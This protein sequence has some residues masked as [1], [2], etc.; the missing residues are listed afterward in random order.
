MVN[1]NTVYK[2]TKKLLNDNQITDRFPIEDWE[3]FAELAQLDVVRRLRKAYE[4]GTIVTDN[5]SNLKAEKL[6]QVVNGAITKP[7]DYLFYNAPLT[8]LFYKDNEGNQKSTLRGVDL[9]TDAELGDR[10]ASQFDKP[11]ITYPI[12]V[13]Y[14]DTFNVYPEE[15]TS[16]KLTYIRKPK[17]P[18]WG[19]IDVDGEPVYDPA[20]SVDF[21]L[22]IDMT[23]ELVYRI[24]ELMGVNVRSADA[25]QYG[26]TKTQQA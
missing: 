5:T 3:D 11:T 22:P 13:D 14:Q 6:I 25:V 17:K 9:V 21:E 12:L 26:A 18:K 19:F 8:R 20:T 1:V 4:S 16:V 24:A 7:E 10:L 15:M 23:G 2:L